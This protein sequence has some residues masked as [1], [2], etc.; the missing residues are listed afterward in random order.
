[1]ICLRVFVTILLGVALAVATAADAT[2]Y[3]VSSSLGN[4]AWSGTLPE[5]NA[6]ASDGPKQ[7][8]AASGNLLDATAQP[9]DRVLLRRGDTWTSSEGLT[10]NT[11]N[12][13]EASLI[14]M[15][16]Y[17]TGDKPILDIS[18][19]GNAITVRGSY[20]DDAS[21]WLR[22]EHLKITTTASPGNRP[23]G[24]FVLES[25]R[26]YIPHHITFSDCIIEGFKHGI[27][28]FQEHHTIENCVIK[29]NYGISPETGYTQGLYA[30][31]NS[32]TIRNNLFENN[33]RPDSW[34]DHNVYVSHGS[35][36]L[37]EGNT[38]RNSLDGI[39][40]RGANNT[41]VRDNVIHGM[42]LGGISVGGD[43][44]VTIENVIIERN[45]IYDTVNGITVVSQSG[46]QTEPSLNI[47]I[48][49]NILHSNR[50]A[51]P[52]GG[53]YGGYLSI[54]DPIDGVFVYNNAFYGISDDNERILYVYS[55][56]PSNLQIKNNIFARTDLTR[57][58]LEISDVSALAG[59]DL[60]NNLY[61]YPGGVIIRVAGVN[62]SDLPSFRADYPTQEAGGVR[63]DPAF[64]DP[65][66]DL[67][68]TAVSVNAID[69]GADATDLVD[70]DFDGAQRPWD[71]D[72]S[73]T[74]EWDIGPYEY[75]S[76]LLIFADGFESGGTT[77]WSLTAG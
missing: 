73:G 44:S 63:G 58:A 46:T 12:G 75:L 53:D 38:V 51:S 27:T 57:S 40:V 4:D 60:D 22:F 2:D 24:I 9:G 10:I 26:P 36:Y 28:L 23:V 37:I 43:D 14:V 52:V 20:N 74:A 31:G 45:L 30:Q 6:G 32:I 70:S 55:A 39:K 11:A 76:P 35:G 69:L 17:G 67:H 13:E 18:G 15:G 41:V 49:N 48:R 29:D 33:G 34:Y 77:D 19:T 47:T 50:P 64:A 21:A 66:A 7:S 65:P 1:M 61:H 59:M 8:L 68:L 16:A 3:Y 5:P 54:T 56:S 25:Y 71:G 72:Q 62:Y 42:N